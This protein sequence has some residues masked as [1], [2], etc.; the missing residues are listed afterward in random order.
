[1]EMWKSFKIHAQAPDDKGPCQ[2][3]GAVLAALRF[4]TTSP[5]QRDFVY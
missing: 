1:M 4:V 5:D 2:K 3:G